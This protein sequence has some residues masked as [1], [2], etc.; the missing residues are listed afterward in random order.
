VVI[1]QPRNH[2]HTLP[3]AQ[4]AS[5]SINLHLDNEII[6][7][8]LMMMWPPL[9]LTSWTARIGGWENVEMDRWA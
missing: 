6:E 5:L 4:A 7:I 3:F 1:I 8:L 9:L 2:G